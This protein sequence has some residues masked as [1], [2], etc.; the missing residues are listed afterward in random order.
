M[1]RRRTS[2]KFLSEIKMVCF[3]NAYTSHSASKSENMNTGILIMTSSNGNIFFALLAFC[4]GNSPVTGE[5]PPQRPV[6]RSFDVSFDLCLNQQLNKQ[7]RP[8]WSKTTSRWLWRLSNALALLWLD[9]VY[10]YDVL[11]ES[12]TGTSTG[13][14]I[15]LLRCKKNHSWEYRK[16]LI[17]YNKTGPVCIYFTY[18]IYPYT[19]YHHPYPRVLKLF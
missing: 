9:L 2:D 13:A 14:I 11:L 17:K 8:R 1:A 6:T 7:W 16:I 15:I 10:S 5:F 4:A 18:I 12:Y 19:I 3:T